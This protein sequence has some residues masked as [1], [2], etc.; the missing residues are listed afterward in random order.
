MRKYFLILTDFA[1]RLPMRLVW[2]ESFDVAAIASGLH[3]IGFEP[4]VTHYEDPELY[5]LVQ[6]LKIQYCLPAT[7]W[8]PIVN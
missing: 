3:R 8:M 5:R 6:D 7:S 2:Y 1:L 4:V